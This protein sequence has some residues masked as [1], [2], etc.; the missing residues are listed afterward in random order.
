MAAS[1]L[2]PPSTPNPSRFARSALCYA[3]PAPDSLLFPRHLTSA[4][5]HLS[6]ANASAHLP[7]GNS[8]AQT[9]PSTR[10]TFPPHDIHS[11]G[12]GESPS[13]LP[14]HLSPRPAHFSLSTPAI[15]P[16]ALSQSPAP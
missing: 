1:N 7:I 8:F 13:P 4:S 15:D 2:T 6:F 14:K 5:H 3:S 16:N 11:H 10:P 9:R 12:S